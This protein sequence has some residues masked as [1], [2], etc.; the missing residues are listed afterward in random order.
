VTPAS[1]TCT[2][3]G[4]DKRRQGN[5]R[6]PHISTGVSDRARSMTVHRTMVVASYPTAAQARVVACAAVGYGLGREH[7]HLP[8]FKLG[9]T[10]H[11]VTVLPSESSV[12]A[13]AGSPVDGSYKIDFQ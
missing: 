3:E 11:G 4:V 12:R 6:D 7:P 13:R 10:R 8:V 2:E 5:S 1:V 9:R